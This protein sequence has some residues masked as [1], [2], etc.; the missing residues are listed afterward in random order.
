[1]TKI[2]I[3]IRDAKI[4]KVWVKLIISR[5]RGMKDGWIVDARMD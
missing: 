2:F 4:K 1:M 5:E 3:M